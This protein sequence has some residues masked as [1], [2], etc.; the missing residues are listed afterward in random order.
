MTAIASRA[1]TNSRGSTPFFFALSTSSDF[2]AREALAIWFRPSISAWIPTPLPPPETEIDTVGSTLA[3]ASAQASARFTRVSDPLLTML[4]VAEEESA[5][6]DA[7]QAATARQRIA[8]SRWSAR[9]M[10]PL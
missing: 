9:R 5:E 3:Y 1:T 6:G 8:G 4:V 2:M 7:E 10:P